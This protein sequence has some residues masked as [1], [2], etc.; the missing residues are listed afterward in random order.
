MQGFEAM[1]QRIVNAEERFISFVMNQTDISRSDAEKVLAF[2]R[3]HK[4]V[5]IDAVCG[6]FTLKHGAFGDADVIRKAV[7]A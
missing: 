7:S 6:Q 1:A 3:K 5:K 2:Y 4:L